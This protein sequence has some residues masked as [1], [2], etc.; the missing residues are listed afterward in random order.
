MYTKVLGCQRVLC[1]ET[2]RAWEHRLLLFG[3]VLAWRFLGWLTS[4]GADFSGTLMWTS[5]EE[6]R[7]LKL[8]AF[9]TAYL[10]YDILQDV[11][12]H[13]GENIHNMMCLEVLALNM[14]K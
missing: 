1:K 9:C 7:R 2:N 12:C 4:L 13:L 3:D 10:A 11:L 14:P 5:V 8:K 6:E